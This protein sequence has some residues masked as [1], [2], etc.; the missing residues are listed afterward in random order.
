MSDYD[1]SYTDFPETIDVV[2]TEYYVG[3]ND[4]AKD[5][6]G[7]EPVLPTTAG[8]S[9]S[10]SWDWLGDVLGS[11]KEAVAYLG[12]GY[13]AKIANDKKLPN[14]PAQVQT[15][16]KNWGWWAVGIGAAVVG[17]YVVV[18]SVRK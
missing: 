9:K 3:W 8:G 1:S 7:Y 13:V 6:G 5:V 12:K 15:Q 18:R 16:V 11:A 17:L 2:P 4:S 10:S 14:S